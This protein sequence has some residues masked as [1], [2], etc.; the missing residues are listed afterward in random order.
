[1]MYY[2]DKAR[3]SHISR[4]KELQAKVAEVKG[5]ELNYFESTEI[6]HY[7]SEL[8]RVIEKEGKPQVKVR[9]GKSNV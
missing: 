1:M 3:A 7:L 4:I 5:T 2:T 9:G 8:I 6:I